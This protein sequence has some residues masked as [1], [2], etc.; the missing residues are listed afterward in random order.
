MANCGYGRGYSV[1]EVL[2]AVRRAHGSDIDVR[3][4]NRRP[5]DAVSIV[6]NASKAR[7]VLGWVPEHDNLDDIVKSALAWEATLGRR[8]QI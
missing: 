3:M 7:E 4:A 5:G 2:D 8:N 6:A 1:L